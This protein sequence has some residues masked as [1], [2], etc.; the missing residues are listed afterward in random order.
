MGEV[1]AC[2]AGLRGM[3]RRREWRMN[4]LNF[5]I[6]GVLEMMLQANLATAVQRLG[7]SDRDLAF[8]RPIHDRSPVTCTPRFSQ[9]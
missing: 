9:S 3:S 8:R 4:S 5:F 6:P 7:E 1:S 2:I